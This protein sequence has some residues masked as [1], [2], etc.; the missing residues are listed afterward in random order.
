M[1]VHQI[2]QAGRAA[3]GKAIVNLL[4]IEPGESMALCRADIAA[5]AMSGELQPNV[6]FELY[7]PKSKRD[8]A[9]EE[10]VFLILKKMQ[11]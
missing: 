3:K 1:K 10:L 11:P 2:P 8:K 7:W 5:D 4:G 9:I 6:A